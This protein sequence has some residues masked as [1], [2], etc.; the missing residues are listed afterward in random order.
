V[1]AELTLPALSPTTDY[2]TVLRWL[3]H[4]GDA[5]AVGEVVVEVEWDK[6]TCEVE[7][8]VAGVLESVIAVEG[9]EVKA[10][11][12]LALIEPRT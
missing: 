7:A 5:V 12:V 3:K 9:D 11:G 1:L 10:G 4:E 6:A 2:A 8:L